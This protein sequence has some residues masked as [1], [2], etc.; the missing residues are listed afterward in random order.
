M[1]VEEVKWTKHSRGSIVDLVLKL[2]KLKK[3][4]KK[5]EA[6]LRFGHHFLVL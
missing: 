4:E 3:I 5:S 6:R 2:K 1:I